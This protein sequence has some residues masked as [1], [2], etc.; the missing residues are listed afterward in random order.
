[1]PQYFTN[2]EC[3]KER[4]QLKNKSVQKV[5]LSVVWVCS[6]ISLCYFSYL[7]F[8][9]FYFP[10]TSGW[11]CCHRGLDPTTCG[12]E[13]CHFFPFP[14]LCV[15]GFVDMCVCVRVGASSVLC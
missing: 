10:L 12:S 15:R 7:I 1:M 9:L 11:L 8:R 6:Y 3:V 13:K 4:T 2:A 5:H 14:G